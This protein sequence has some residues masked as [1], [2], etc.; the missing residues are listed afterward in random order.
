M[1]GYDDGETIN[2]IPRHHDDNVTTDYKLREEG[3]MLLT[4]VTVAQPVTNRYQA[5]YWAQYGLNNFP[6]QQIGL[7]ILIGLIRFI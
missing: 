4:L 7:I 3:H 2:S 5:S 6:F 1:A